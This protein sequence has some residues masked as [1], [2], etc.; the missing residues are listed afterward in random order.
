MLGNYTNM[1]RT[2]KENNDLGDDKN[3]Y[4][5]GKWEIVIRPFY[6]LWFIEIN[7]GVT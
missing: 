4:I 3:N 2:K 6:L 1:M 7:F 5:S